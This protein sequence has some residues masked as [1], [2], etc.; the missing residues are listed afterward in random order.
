MEQV[1]DGGRGPGGSW[2]RF[3]GVPGR[4]GGTAVEA[5]NKWAGKV[6]CEQVRAPGPAYEEQGGG[7]WH[8]CL[9]FIVA[10]GCLMLLSLEGEHS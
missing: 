4:G 1:S 2:R 10:P 7:L 8:G 6:Q 9:V 3:A 5:E